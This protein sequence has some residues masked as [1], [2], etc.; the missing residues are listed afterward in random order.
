MEPDIRP[1]SACGRPMDWSQDT[2]PTCKISRRNESAARRRFWI[3]MAIGLLTT[4][5][6]LLLAKWTEL[7]L[8]HA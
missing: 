5:L 4:L 3:C 6:A 8:T 7:R 2:C 1:C